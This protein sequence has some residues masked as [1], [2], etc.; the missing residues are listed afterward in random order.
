MPGASEVVRSQF[1][2]YREQ[3]ARSAERLLDDALR[4]TSPQDDHIDKR[5]FMERCFPTAD[6]FVRQ[7][8]RQISEVAPGLVVLCYVYQLQDGTTHSN[9]EL[10]T[11][12][13][14]RITEIRVYF[15]GPDTF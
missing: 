12:D 11:V 2:A 15:G 10:I 8:I 13:S 1:E 9:I 5:T 14:G 4:F 6:R 7:E 3:D